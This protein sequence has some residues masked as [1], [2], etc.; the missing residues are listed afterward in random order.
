LARLHRATG[1]DFGADGSTTEGPRKQRVA[2]QP[3]RYDKSRWAPVLIAWADEQSFPRL[4]GYIAGVG[5]PQPWLTRSGHLAYVSGQV[6]LDRLQLDRVQLPDRAVARAIIL[7]E[8]GHLVGL[9]HTADRSQIMHSEAQFN[10]QDYGA[11]D[12]RGLAK[13]GTRACVPEL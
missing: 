7:H 2:Y 10:V 1:L 6:V 13:L 12:L 8:L 3:E 9:D 11:G 4:A 5:A